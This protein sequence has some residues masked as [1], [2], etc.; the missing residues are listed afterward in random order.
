MLGNLLV[1]DFR[2]E[3]LASA[4]LGAW[5][6]GDSTGL[7]WDLYKQQLPQLSWCQR[8]KGQRDYPVP[9][10]QQVSMETM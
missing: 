5:G 4:E 7:L 1:L 2:G 8:A 3:D 6:S 10:A 9:G